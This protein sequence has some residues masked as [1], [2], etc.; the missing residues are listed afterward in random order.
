MLSLLTKLRLLLPFLGRAKGVDWA[1]I[2]A[3]LTKGSWRTRAAAVCAVLLFAICVGLSL[4]GIDVPDGVWALVPTVAVAVVG[5][6]AREEKV[7]SEQAGA[8]II[9][10]S[11]PPPDLPDRPE[12]QRTDNPRWPPEIK[13]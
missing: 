12:V 4:L 6:M 8:G 5:W 11:D 9:E 7:S 3:A 10:P 1:G 13:P 2:W